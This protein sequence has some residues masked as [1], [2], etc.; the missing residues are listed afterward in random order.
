[1]E[2]PRTLPL[3]VVLKPNNF[4]Y[5]QSTHLV[6]GLRRRSRL[7]R[8]CSINSLR[9]CLSVPDAARSVCNLLGTSHFLERNIRIVGVSKEIEAPVASRLKLLGEGIAFRARRNT[10]ILLSPAIR[11]C[12]PLVCAPVEHAHSAAGHGQIE[13]VLS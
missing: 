1:M 5:W 13:V 6:L 9:W 12:S 2:S 3:Y 7:R 11:W 4:R 10:T 8:V